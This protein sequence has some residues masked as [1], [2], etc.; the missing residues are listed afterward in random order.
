MN[1]L[2]NPYALIAILCFLAVSYAAAQ[3]K[4]DLA[5][6]GFAFGISDD[7]AE[8]IIESSGRRIMDNKVDS[9]KI[10][11]IVMQGMIVTLPLDLEGRDVSTGLEFYDDKLL[12]SSLMLTA[13]DQFEESQLRNEFMKYLTDKYGEPSSSDSML[14]FK[15]W[16]WNM[17]DVKLVF[18]TNQKK[19]T[20]KVDYTYEP[21]NQAKREEELD[22]LRGTEAKDPAKQMFIDGD[23]SK[24]KYYDETGH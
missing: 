23:Y 24:P 5:P 3:Q 16:T 14:Y 6:L 20:I 17:P 15:T 13:K 9:K 12:S 1:I 10:R 8:D 2:R 4:P 11:T 18:H 22:K 19:N 21:Y 7:D